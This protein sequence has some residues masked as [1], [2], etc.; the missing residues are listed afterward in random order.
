MAE[1]LVMSHRSA[2]HHDDP[3]DPAEVG[4]IIKRYM[5]WTNDLRAKGKL[6]A[7]R[8]LQTDGRVVKPGAS[9]TDGPFAEGTEVVG[10]FWLIEAEN[11]DEAMEIVATHPHCQVWP[12]GSLEVRP[13]LDFGPR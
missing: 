2:D 1:F 9:V 8:R 6:K 12:D 11:L 7:S 13:I 5:D 3:I 4:G 10:G